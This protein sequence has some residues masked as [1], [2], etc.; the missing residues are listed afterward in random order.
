MK[1][2]GLPMKAPEV[3]ALL[4]G[5][6]TQTRRVVKLPRWAHPDAEI[7]L[8]AD[9]ISAGEWPF[10]SARATGCLAA[11]SCPYGDFG[12]LL[13]VRETWQSAEQDQ[14][15]N[16]DCYR[17]DIDDVAAREGFGPW[18]PSIHMPRQASRLTLRLTDVRVQRLQEISEEEAKAEGVQM[19]HAAMQMRS[20]TWRQGYQIVWEQINGPGSWAANPC[21]WALSFETIRQNVDA[22]IALGGGA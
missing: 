12:D 4:A 17:A 19:S 20:G 15:G 13:W 21:V 5:T 6:K 8:N 10:T 16:T 18:T 22:V 3:R 1:T 9:S 2:T 7:E 14:D 11:I